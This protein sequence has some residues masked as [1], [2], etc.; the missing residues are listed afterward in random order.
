MQG[1]GDAEAKGSRSAN[2]QF[3]NESHRMLYLSIECVIIHCTFFQ[4]IDKL[5]VGEVK[6]IENGASTS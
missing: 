1:W 4:R 6:F 2:L 5:K 3:E